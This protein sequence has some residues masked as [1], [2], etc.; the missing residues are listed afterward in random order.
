MPLH[1]A[2]EGGSAEGPGRRQGEKIKIPFIQSGCRHCSVP[3]GGKR[4]WRAATKRPQEE[5]FHQI[6]RCPR[7]CP[8]AVLRP[9]H[10]IPALPWHGWPSDIRR[11]AASHHRWT[12]WEEDT[13]LLRQWLAQESSWQTSYQAGLSPRAA[14]RHSAQEKARRRRAYMLSAVR[15][16]TSSSQDRLAMVM[17]RWPHA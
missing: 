4:C 6:L 7:P 13:A 8:A 16:P 5:I 14:I 3:P 17:R 9:A 2:E 15:T 1:P 11:H 10:P 12:R